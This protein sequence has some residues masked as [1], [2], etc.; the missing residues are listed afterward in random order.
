MGPPD[1]A[2]LD[3]LPYVPRDCVRAILAPHLRRITAGCNPVWMVL[4]FS[5]E[6]PRASRQRGLG[7]RDSD[8]DQRVRRARNPLAQRTASSH[9]PNRH[10]GPRRISTN[11]L[12]PLSTRP[13]EYFF[14]D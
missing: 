7:A 8:G 13:G 12:F 11:T 3:R 5:R 2:E 1:A 6:I 9:R 10:H 14:G 4:E